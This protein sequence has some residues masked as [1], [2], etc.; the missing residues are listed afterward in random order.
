MPL[1]PSYSSTAEFCE[2]VSDLPTSVGDDWKTGLR[3]SLGPFI[4]T[5]LQGWL[6]MLNRETE[7]GLTRSWSFLKISA[8]LDIYLS[9]ILMAWVW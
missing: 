3:F 7:I 9:I 2:A 8:E 6:F 4:L 5:K 1:L